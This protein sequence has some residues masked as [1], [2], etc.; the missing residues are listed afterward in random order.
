MLYLLALLEYLFAALCLPVLQP[1]RFPSG[2]AILRP[3]L[4]LK[5]GIAD[6]KSKIET[7]FSILRCDSQ[8]CE[9]ASLKYLIINRESKRLTKEERHDSQFRES[10][11]REKRELCL[12]KVS[13]INRPKS[14][15]A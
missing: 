11:K 9:C 13:K 2:M 1:I 14:G 7:P 5:S 6:Q 8:F 12:S 3:G 15:G 10:Q 4:I